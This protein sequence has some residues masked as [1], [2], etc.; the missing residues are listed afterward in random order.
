[1]EAVNESI[2]GQKFRVM[3]AF[4]YSKEPGKK[5]MAG[6]RMTGKCVYVHPNGRFA[7]LEFAF[8]S[9]EVLREAFRPEDLRL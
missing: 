2:I 7:V 3:P 8:K 4:T 1:M 6:K 5:S 9:G